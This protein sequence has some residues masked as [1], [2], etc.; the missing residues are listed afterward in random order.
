M[1]DDM[2]DKPAVPDGWIEFEYS[3]P[4]PDAVV[5]ELQKQQRHKLHRPVESGV[6]E[7]RG[8]YDVIPL[9]MVLGGDAKPATVY[10]TPM[11]HMVLDQSIP[12]RGWYKSKIEADRVRPRPCYTESL[13]TSP[14]LGY[15]PVGCS[16]S[17]LAGTMVMTLYGEMAIEDFEAGDWV[18]GRFDYGLDWSEV[19]A[20]TH[21]KSPGYYHVKLSNGRDWKITAGHL[22][23]VVGQGWVDVKELFDNHEGVK[24]E[25]VQ[26]VANDGV[27]TEQVPGGYLL[28]NAT[29]TSMK[30]VEGEVDVY[31]IQTTSENF[32]ASGVLV[33]NCYINNGSRGYRATGLPTVDPDYPEKYHKQLKKVMVAGAG[34]MTSFSEAFHKLEDTYHVTE[35]LTQVFVDE[36]LPIFY[37]TR[38]IPMEFAVEAL[39]KNPYSYCQFSIN[40]SNPDD[41]R[42]LS[43]GAAKLEEYYKMINRLHNLGVYVSIQCNP[44][45]PGITSL[46]ELKQLVRDL[47]SVGTDHIIFKFVEQVM[48]TRKVIVD[49]LASRRFD[50][51]K[52][53]L[54]DKLFNQVIGGVYTIQ[55]DVRIEWLEELL[56]ETR[57]NH[58][59]MST[60]YEYYENGKAGANLAPYFTTSDQ[61]HGRG[62]PIHYRPKP[63][64]K[65]QP[66]PGCYRKG[67]LYC[68]DHG[69]RACRS[70]TLLEAKALEYKDLVNTVITGRDEDWDMAESCARPEMEHANP[71]ANPGYM[72]DAELWGWIPRYTPENAI[73][74]FVPAQEQHSGSKDVLDRAEYE[75]HI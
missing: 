71:N 52:V 68:A 27:R 73:G 69:T 66:L 1:T 33:H 29:I 31:D 63:G 14:F 56:A 23:W 32:Y 20:T 41:Y 25:E 74:Q 51:K 30:Y 10:K 70:E 43:P 44:I 47:A 39:Q 15:C 26:A 11:K 9:A 40:T 53:D 2:K 24:L 34:Y 37:C 60:C 54:F 13:L 67:C 38:R 48:N 45:H 36:G 59:T 12:P 35:R 62:V 4:D 28:G 50:P 58:M 6:D 57:A 3:D 16:F 19:L 75:Q 17:L 49:R 42:K 72:T 61:C 8:P 5:E 65:F 64:E 18:L 21:H 46:E 22:V 55:Q 7:E